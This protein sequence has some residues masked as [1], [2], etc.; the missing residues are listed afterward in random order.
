M[1][2]E[3][4]RRE[5]AEFL[6]ANR[7]AIKLRV[8]ES[9][10]ETYPQM[11]MLVS[12][13]EV[14]QWA[15]AEINSLADALSRN[16]SDTLSYKGFYGY[17]VST[18]SQPFRTF[19]NFLEWEYFFSRLIASFLYA[20]AGRGGAHSRELISCF[21]VF[22]LR[23]LQ[24]N[25]QRLLNDVLTPGLI[26]EA[27]VD[28]TAS[29][30]LYPRQSFG[31]GTQN[32]TSL[33]T[34]AGGLTARERELAGLVA[35]GLSNKEISARMGISI[36]TTKNHVSNILSKLHLSNRTELALLLGQDNIT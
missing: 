13:N 28:H 20:Q 27:L 7:E 12:E 30:G 3:S 9:I 11:R 1:E 16:A 35:R 2:D 31:A 33:Q 25:T 29:M 14:Q 22:I 4:L 15:L 26:V 17:F 18:A 21:E 6:V 10:F 23:V 5:L 32:A 19:F 8:S 34:I 24:E 36:A